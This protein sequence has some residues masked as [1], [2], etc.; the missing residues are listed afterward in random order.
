MPLGSLWSGY[1]ATLTSA[2][3]VLAVNGTLVSA[4]ALYFLVRGHGI[5]RL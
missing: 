4:I 1:A 2:P 3:F 5:R